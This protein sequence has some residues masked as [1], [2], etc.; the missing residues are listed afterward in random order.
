MS[1]APLL[2]VTD[3]VA[4]FAVGQ[5]V[6]RRGDVQ[7]VAG[8]SFAID[9]GESLGLVGESGCGKS[10]VA[11]TIVGLMRPRS[12]S[13]H[14]DGADITAPSRTL[15]QRRAIQMVF[16]DPFSSLNRRMTV[17]ELI[18]E[19]WLVHTGIEPRDRWD[20]RVAELL[21]M[22]GLAKRHADLLPTQFSGGQ[23]QR[24]SIARALAVRPRLLIADEAVS[25]LDVSVQAQIL[26]LLQELRA[27]LDLAM[28]F[29]SHDLS[30]VRHICDRVAVMYLG[31]IVETG[32]RD[33][34]FE[35]P[36]HPYTQ[37]LMSAV[38]DL[39]PWRTVGPLR[40]LDDGEVP[41]PAD[42][43]SGCRFRTRC[44]KAAD[45]CAVQEP[46]LELRGFEH[47]VACH[48]AADDAFAPISKERS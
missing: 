3:L 47:P 24:I 40:R 38:P 16:Q 2:E 44:P 28:L 15:Q 39:Y 1:N 10:T 32:A 17:R 41:S 7:A 18:S 27:E 37:A 22:V 35:H 20:E 48:F 34:L 4:A 14:L 25:S 19:P 9:A 33:D 46:L 42:P 13:V 36:L 11:R 8:V 30:V 5:G 26:N 43:P 6:F 23:L 29:I 31:K 21:E 12:G 45:L